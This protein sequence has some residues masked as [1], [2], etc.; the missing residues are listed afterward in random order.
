DAIRRVILL[1]RVSLYGPGAARLH[2]EIVPV[3]ARWVEPE[4]RKGALSPYAREAEARTLSLLETA[5]LDARQPMPE[6]VVRQLQ[7]SAPRD[8]RELLPFLETRGHEFIRDAE[9]KLS[10]RGAAEAKAMRD[11]LETQKKHIE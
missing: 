1:G 6:I 9:Q 4:I 11:I 3:T 8:V 5:L 2:E 10:E 7:S